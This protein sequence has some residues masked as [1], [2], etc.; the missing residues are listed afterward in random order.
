MVSHL[1]TVLYCAGKHLISEL[2]F[3][4]EFNHSV[5]CKDFEYDY[6]LTINLTTL[7]CLGP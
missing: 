4:P 6:Y 7:V 5:I 1:E 3:S 2:P